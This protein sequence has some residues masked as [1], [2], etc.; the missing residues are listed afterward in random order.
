MKYIK[1]YES[2]DMEDFYNIFQDLKDS[3]Q[4]I[5]WTFSEKAIKYISEY[6]DM[7][8]FR[9]W[10]QRQSGWPIIGKSNVLEY[11]LSTKDL[12]K[13]NTEFGVIKG[14]L[15]DL[16]VE[17]GYAKKPEPGLSFAGFYRYVIFLKNIKSI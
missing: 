2:I 9:G 5:E 13:L 7:D 4:E 6:K 8:K 3:F 10:N 11:H 12:A 17:I 16:G 14:R 15:N 1:V